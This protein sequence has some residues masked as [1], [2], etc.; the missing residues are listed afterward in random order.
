MRLECRVRGNKA[1]SRC[2]QPKC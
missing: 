1:P 2:F